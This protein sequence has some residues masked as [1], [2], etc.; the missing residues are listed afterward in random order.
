MIARSNLLWCF[1]KLMD[2][3]VIHTVLGVTVKNYP[4]D[5]VFS[6]YMVEIDHDAFFFFL[7]GNQF[8]F[9][10]MVIYLCSLH[11]LPF[12]LS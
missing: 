2:N 7:S 10:L 6:A 4:E 12:K 11:L 3:N 1:V 8:S 9:P 5:F